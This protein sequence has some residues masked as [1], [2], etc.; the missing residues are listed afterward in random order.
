MSTETMSS[1]NSEPSHAKLVNSTGNGVF[2]ATFKKRL[3]QKHRQK[4]KLAGWIKKR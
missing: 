2:D 1:N 3:K 4:Y